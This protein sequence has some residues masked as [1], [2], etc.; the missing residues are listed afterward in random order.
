MDGRNGFVES[1]SYTGVQANHMER[2]G[3]D[4]VALPYKPS[5]QNNR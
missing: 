4:A 3:E 2:L 5:F 1:C